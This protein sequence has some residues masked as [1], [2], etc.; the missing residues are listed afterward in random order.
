MV[1]CSKDGFYC[2]K[3][4]IYIFVNPKENVRI[5]GSLNLYGMKI[6]IKR[7]KDGVIFAKGV[8]DEINEKGCYSSGASKK[9]Y[10]SY[11]YVVSRS[12][13]LKSIS[14]NLRASPDEPGVNYNLSPKSQELLKIR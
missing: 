14:I 4:G 3:Y 1:N 6:S 10:M 5:R 7:M 11:V 13:Y 12:G 9:P 2:Q 8:C